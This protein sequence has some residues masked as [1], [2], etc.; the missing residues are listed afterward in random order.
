MSNEGW[1]PPAADEGSEEELQALA[2]TINY[3]ARALVLLAREIA[4]QGVQSTHADIA[5]LM[6][7]LE[8]KHPGDRENSLFASLELSLRRLSPEERALLPVL[9]PSQGGNNWQVWAI[10]LGGIEENKERVTILGKA[11]GS[12]GTGKHPELWLYPAGSGPCY[13]PS[14][15]TSGRDI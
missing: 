9:A 6:A 13:L 11:P 15:R 5:Q 2:K 1:E 7:G 4:T 3:H 14:T 12:S 10:M 8:Q